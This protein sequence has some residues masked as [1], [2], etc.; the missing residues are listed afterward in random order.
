MEEKGKKHKREG[1]STPANIEKLLEEELLADLN[2]IGTEKTIIHSDKEEKQEEAEEEEIELNEIEQTNP[3]EIPQKEE[4]KLTEYK[5]HVIFWFY[6]VILLILMVGVIMLAKY[7]YDPSKQYT[8]LKPIETINVEE[9]L[10]HWNFIYPKPTN[11]DLFKIISDPM[12]GE[13]IAVGADSTILLSNYRNILNS[14]NTEVPDSENHL[15]NQLNCLFNQINATNSEDNEELKEEWIWIL[16]NNLGEG[17]IRSLNIV[18]NYLYITLIK[19]DLSVQSYFTNTSNLFVPHT[20]PLWLSAKNIF[21][22]GVVF[23]KGFLFFPNFSFYFFIFLFFYF[24]FFILFLYFSGMKN[25]NIDNG[26]SS[27]PKC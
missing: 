16:N 13:F 10:Q 8:P 4:K 14:S 22:A 19:N 5:K 24:F 2:G 12:T 26:N 25:S 27:F 9:Y 21:N 6:W 20:A 23:G 11:R 18:G 17:T 7:L 15:K 1:S 3:I